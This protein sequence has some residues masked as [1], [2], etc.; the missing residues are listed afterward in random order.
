[1]NY[2]LTHLRASFLLIAST[3]LVLWIVAFWF[4]L[5]DYL[6]F[7][8]SDNVSDYEVI[9]KSVVAV[10]ISFCLVNLLVA[11]LFATRLPTSIKFWSAVIPAGILFLT[12]FIAAIPI[13]VKFPDRNYFEVF[14]AMFRLFRFTKPDTFALALA[15]ISLATA[16]NL[17][18]A[19]RVRKAGDAEKLSTKLRLRYLGYTAAVVLVAAVFTAVN[20][21]NTNY[22]A[23]DRLSCQQYSLRALP[24]LDEEVAAFLSDVMLYGQSAGTTKMQNAFVTFSMISRQ[25]YAALGSD[26][27]SQTLAQLEFNV[28]EAKQAVTDLCSEFGPETSTPETK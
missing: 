11:G 18:A 27:D 5:G 16:L 1:M 4:P 6:A 23:Y 3:A 19:F 9:L 14:Q 26:A 24:E 7:L 10:F 13:A 28:A 12:P 15:F 8:S 2:R 17:L 20:L 21:V 25:Y 22:R